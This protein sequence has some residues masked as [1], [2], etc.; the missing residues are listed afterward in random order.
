MPDIY[1]LAS[2]IFLP[3]LRDFLNI[4]IA[5][6]IGHWT[7]KYHY[8]FFIIAAFYLVVGIVLHLF[9]YKWIKKGIN[10]LII[11]QLLQ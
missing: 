4:G 5:L 11:T 10:D 9:L 2:N 8:G 1:N 3:T 6:L 7:G